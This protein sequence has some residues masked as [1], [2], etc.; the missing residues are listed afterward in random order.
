M[1]D[2]GALKSKTKGTSS[3]LHDAL[4]EVDVSPGL[5]RKIGLSNWLLMRR[6]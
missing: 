5:L 3:H 1:T 4:I 6:P 2:T